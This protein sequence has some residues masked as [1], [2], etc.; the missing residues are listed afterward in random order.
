MI[1]KLREPR[2]R[3][4]RLRIDKRGA[5]PYRFLHYRYLS[6]RNSAVECQLPKLDVAGSI[7][8]AR[9]KL[10]KINL[11]SFPRNQYFWCFP[12]CSILRVVPKIFFLIGTSPQCESHS[13]V[14]SRYHK[15]AS[16][17]DSTV[18]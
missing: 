13:F 14:Q 9:S 5:I 11:L 15:P 3:S 10:F 1:G 12:K 8:V 17:V 7:P 18:I 6:G 4:S 2:K 16:V